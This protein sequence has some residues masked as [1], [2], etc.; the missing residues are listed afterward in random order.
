[1]SEPEHLMLRLG[2]VIEDLQLVLEDMRREAVQ[3]QDVPDMSARC[4]LVV[5]RHY[6]LSMRHIVGASR[7]SL[8]S[9]PRRVLVY[10]LRQVAGM[11]WDDIGAML[12]RDHTTCIYNH[13][14]VKRDMGADPA[15]RRTVDDMVAQVV[16]K[17]LAGEEGE[18]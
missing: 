13:G 18:R 15:F 17:A 16:Q 7:T 12:R 6:G 5:T 9:L 10:L 1:M 8:V 11:S 3:P 2:R 4:V 14:V